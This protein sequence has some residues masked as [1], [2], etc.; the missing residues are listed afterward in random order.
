MA[1]ICSTV[2]VP[3]LANSFPKSIGIAELKLLATF[4]MN[5]R[6]EF[7]FNISFFTSPEL[8]ADMHCPS[9]T[10]SLSPFHVWHHSQEGF[11]QRF[12]AVSVSWTNCPKLSSIL[13]SESCCLE[14]DYRPGILLYRVHFFLVGS[15]L[16][17]KKLI[18]VI[19]G[20]LIS[21]HFH[22]YKYRIHNTS[23]Q[24]L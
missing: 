7:S 22:S 19:L 23:C 14:F 13:S 3:C 6:E 8:S 21:C 4:A 1:F 20:W 12:L 2:V 18:S 15:Y 9:N 5:L 10:D 16:F 17:L 11:L 24:S